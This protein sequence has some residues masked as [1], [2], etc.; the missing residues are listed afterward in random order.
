M[1][2]AISSKDLM[3]EYVQHT[4]SGLFAIPG[5]ISPGDHVGQAL[6]D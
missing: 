1:Q 4:G 2:T 5:G 3:Q 6:F